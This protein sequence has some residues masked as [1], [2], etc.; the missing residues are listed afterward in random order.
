MLLC[1]PK[2]LGRDALSLQGVTVPPTAAQ[3]KGFTLCAVGGSTCRGHGEGWM[4]DLMREIFNCFQKQPH[5]C[6]ALYYLD[7]RNNLFPK[8]GSKC[9]T[10][11][12]ILW[13]APS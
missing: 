5:V 8:I 1:S 11:A 3:G 2:Q 4:H 12:K 9:V 6:C 10:L 7:Q 13:K